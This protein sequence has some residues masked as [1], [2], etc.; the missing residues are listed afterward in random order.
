[1]TGM[2]HEQDGEN[3]SRMV[4]PYRTCL[5]FSVQVENWWDYQSRM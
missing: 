1:M 4:V 3:Q 2:V 5:I